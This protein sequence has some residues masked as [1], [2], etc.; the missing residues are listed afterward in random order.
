MNQCVAVSIS[1]TS[2]FGEL[3]TVAAFALL[4]YLAL[5][6]ISISKKFPKS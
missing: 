2:L 5:I 4:T 6:S 3:K 1:G